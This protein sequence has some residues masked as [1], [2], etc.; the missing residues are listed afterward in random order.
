MFWMLSFHLSIVYFEQITHMIPVPAINGGQERPV[1]HR[2]TTGYTRW[3]SD[4]SPPPIAA[5]GALSR[6]VKEPFCSLT[7]VETRNPSYSFVHPDGQMFRAGIMIWLV[8][9]WTWHIAH[10]MS[11]WLRG[12]SPVFSFEKGASSNLYST[13]YI[14]DCHASPPFGNFILPMGFLWRHSRL[15]PP[16]VSL[17]FPLAAFPIKYE[18]DTQN[19]VSKE[20][21]S[22]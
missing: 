5:S 12:W 2:A 13:P 8:L 19:C 21:H 20:I 22:K 9:V 6:H 14:A 16:P 1:L 11:L 18:K 15:L 10:G 17:Y 3:L 7:C 4:S